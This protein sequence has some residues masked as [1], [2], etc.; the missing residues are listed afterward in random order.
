M[1]ENKVP[2]RSEIPI[3]YTWNASSVF[4]TL[5]DWELEVEKIP[6]D[7]KWLRAFQ[8][9]LKNNPSTLADALKLRDAIINR[10]AKVDMFAY[11]SNQV[12]KTD[13]EAASMVGKAK[14]L[15][16]QA[17]AAGA[18]IEPEILKIGWQ[19]ALFGAIKKGGK[20]SR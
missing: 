17:L 8:G 18:F 20:E 15:L 10:V 16:G 19:K 11:I 4:P 7:L 5:S 1:T 9:T 2:Y 13:Q 12:D 3:E 14:A 6:G